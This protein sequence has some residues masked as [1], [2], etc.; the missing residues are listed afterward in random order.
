[1]CAV[2][3]YNKLNAEELQRFALLV[4]S[5][6]SELSFP[7]F[8]NSVLELYGPERQHLLV[9]RSLSQHFRP[10]EGKS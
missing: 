9:G 6:H 5:W 1:M 8:I 7:D 4:K 10:G 3:L 2:Q